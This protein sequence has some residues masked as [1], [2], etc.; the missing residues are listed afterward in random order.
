[1]KNKFLKVLLQIVSKMKLLSFGLLFVVVASILCA[2]LPPLVL[3]RIINDLTSHKTIMLSL[4]LLYFGLIVIANLCESAKESFLIVFGQKITHGLRSQLCQKLSCM[5]VETLTSQEPGETVSRI[6]NDVDTIETLFTSGIF[7]MIADACK[8]VSIFVVIFMKN[9][10]LAI[11]LVS[12]MP[13]IFIFTRLVQKRMLISQIQNRVAVGKVSQHVPQTIRTIRTIHNLGIE[14]Y[15]TKKYDQAIQESYGAIKKTNFYDAIYSP[16]ILMVNALVVG[17]AMLLASSRIGLFSM[18]V[19][20]AVA[21]IDYISKVF[22]PIESIGME[23]QTIQSALAGVYRINEFLNIEERFKTDEMMKIDDFDFS[24]PCIEV[25]DLDFAYD[26]GHLI[27][28]DFNMEV[29]SGEMVT[30]VGRTGAGKSTLFKL[31]LGMYQPRHGEMKIYGKEASLIPDDLKRQMFGY[32]EQSFHLV[33]GTIYDQIAL[34]DESL[35]VD[36]VQNAA[37]LVGLHETI[38]SFENGYET[39]CHPSLF[40]QGQWQL[41]SIARA[42]VSEPK[43]L[44][45]DE[46]TANLDAKT[47]MDVL[48]ALQNASKN[49]TVLSISH[50]LYETNGGRIVEIA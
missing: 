41:L 38:I 26:K 7:S 31:L 49:R 47:E 30:L 11:L 23:I 46:I 32:V 45:L 50:R 35:T 20:T 36:Q 34:F 39:M 22:E 40:S 3:E 37:K 25:T 28:N 43:I 10:G 1:M 27:L 19:G 17:I 21:M 16:I 9:R 13:L 5:S 48:S 18:S 6:V 44:L 2:L 42:I 14:K 12:V 8:I 33:P 24:L 15:M 4:P 29:Q